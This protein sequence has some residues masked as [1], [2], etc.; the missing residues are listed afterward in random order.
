MS[1]Q[2]D[3]EPQYTARYWR[4][5]SQQ[6]QEF[7]TQDEAVGFLAESWNAGDCPPVSVVAPDGRTVLEGDELMRE[8]HRCF[9]ADDRSGAP[10]HAHNVCFAIAGRRQTGPRARL[11]P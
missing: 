8:V 11:E 9:R 7:D 5:H 3:E 6:E 2:A 10:S 1:T 4:Y